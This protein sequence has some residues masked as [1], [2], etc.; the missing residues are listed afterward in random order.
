MGGFD[1]A[2]QIKDTGMRTFIPFGEVVTEH[3]GRDD[4]R[5]ILLPPVF[6]NPVMAGARMLYLMPDFWDRCRSAGIRWP[7]VRPYTKK[8]PFTFASHLSHN[9]WV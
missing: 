3:I 2:T 7:A 5:E 9:S 4:G 1:K 6:F 8:A